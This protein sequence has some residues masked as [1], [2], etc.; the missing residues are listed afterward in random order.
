MACLFADGKLVEGEAWRQEGFLGTHFIGS[1]RAGDEG[2]MPTIRGDA[3]ITGESTLI[4]DREDPFAGG[5][6]FLWRASTY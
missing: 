5:I 2:V 4:F 3:W 6:K 1:V